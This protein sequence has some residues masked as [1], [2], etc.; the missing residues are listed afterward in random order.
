MIY[1]ISQVT[2]I[3]PTQIYYNMNLI[4]SPSNFI[5][6]FTWHFEINLC[7]LLLEVNFCSTQKMHVSDYVCKTCF[8]ELGILLKCRETFKTLLAACNSSKNTG[9][10]QFFFKKETL[11]FKNT[12][13]LAKTRSCLLCRPLWIQ[14]YHMT[15]KCLK[16]PV[17]TYI[18]L[19]T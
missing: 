17:Q 19:R 14:N 13:F 18:L 7:W 9:L 15:G 1:L 11:Y 2:F 3:F 4:T 6:R 8:K 16:Y 10:L 5:T 12:Y